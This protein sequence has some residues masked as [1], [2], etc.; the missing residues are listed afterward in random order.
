MTT[1]VGKWHI[2]CLWAPFLHKMCHIKSKFRWTSIITRAIS[3]NIPMKFCATLIQEFKHS[4]PVSL[5]YDTLCWNHGHHHCIRQMLPVE[6]W[7][8]TYNRGKNENLSMPSTD[9]PRMLSDTAC[10]CPSSNCM[11]SCSYARVIAQMK[12]GRLNSSMLI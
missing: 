1:L 12:R 10:F 5:I 7:N 9:M 6:G 8:H 4:L 2:F 11:Q 3:Y